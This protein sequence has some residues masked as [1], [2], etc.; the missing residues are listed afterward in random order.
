MRNYYIQIHEY[1]QRLTTLVVQTD[2]NEINQQGISVNLME[3]ALLQEL[4]RREGQTI[5]EI[6]ES[7]GRSRNEVTAMVRRLIKQQLIQK[8]PASED[9]RVRRLILT[10]TGGCMVKN[11]ETQSLRMLTGL[12][13]DFSFNE[14]KAV[15][16]FLVKLDMLT[17]NEEIEGIRKRVAA[18]IKNK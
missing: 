1:L 10:E 14:E 16:K 8:G 11:I 6:M 3:Y 12:L 17:R 15:L 4:R 5:Q 18:R 9:R 2:R 7:T 13:D